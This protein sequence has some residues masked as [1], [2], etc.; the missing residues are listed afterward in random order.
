MKNIQETCIYCGKNPKET[1][2]HVPPKSFYPKPRPS[3]LITVP[4]CL[5]CNQS[6]GKDEEFFLA[7]FM[8]S[9]AGIS[10]AGQRLWSEKVHRMFQKNVGLKRKIAEGLKYAN[11]VTPAGIFIGRRLLVSTDETRFD[12]VVNK[13]VKGLYYFEYNE[14]LPLEAE[15]TTLF[16]TTQENFEL[17][18][19]YVNQL[20]QGSKGWK[21]IFE[22][23]HNRAM[24]RKVGSMWLLLFY[25]F[26]A[27][28]TVTIEKEY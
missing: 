25:N 2:D 28:W 17:V 19:S 15:I 5:R 18:G 4:S 27:F 21:G 10:K 3:D 8:F 14:P 23:K 11:L 26:A 20:V 6:A 16:L 9:H 1:D 22:Y 12:N 24:D 13:I 7:T